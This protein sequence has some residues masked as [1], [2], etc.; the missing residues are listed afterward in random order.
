M[1]SLTAEEKSHFESHVIHT[2]NF[3]SQ[4][5]WTKDLRRIPEIALS[6]HE[7]LNGRGYP[8]KL[9]APEIPL[10][11][12]L[13]MIA[14]IFDALTAADRPYKKAVPLERALNILQDEKR[15]GAINPALVDLFIDARVY[16]RVIAR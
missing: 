2:Y 12:E 6:H 1:G 3:L 16:Q 8:R 9:S 15:A 14:D 4:M 7:R 13:I 11:A 5:P 10:Q